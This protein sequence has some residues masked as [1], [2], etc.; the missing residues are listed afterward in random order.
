MSDVRALQTRL[1][2]ELYDELKREVENWGGTMNSI[3]VKALEEYFISRSS[4]NSGYSG[5]RVRLGGGYTPVDKNDL[6]TNLQEYI[7]NTNLEVQSLHVF[8]SQRSFQMRLAYKVICNIYEDLDGNFIIRQLIKQLN[9]NQRD[10]AGVL[11]RA[12]YYENEA[13]GAWKHFFKIYG[14]YQNK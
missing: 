2:V 4:N 10:S 6:I 9:E 5:A 14:S 12:S 13:L 3:V 7:E 1:P 11:A 8:L